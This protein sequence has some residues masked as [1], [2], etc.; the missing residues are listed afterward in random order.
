YI[1]SVLCVVYVLQAGHSVSAQKPKFCGK[2]DCPPFKV[3]NKTADYELRLYE[4]SEWV[5]NSRVTDSPFSYPVSMFW[6]LFWYIMGMNKGGKTMSWALP[7][8]M[9]ITLPTEIGQKWNIGMCF[10]LKSKS[11]PEP[12]NKK[13]FLIK[14]PA[15]KI[16]VRSFDGFAKPK[17]W[18]EHLKTLM[19]AL[20]DGSYE[21]SYFYT[22]AYNSPFQKKNRHN[23]VWL[24]AKN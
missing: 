19:N 10:Y 17:D 21:G 3:L 15:T 5:S 23:E 24:V 1:L 7:G 20:P 18:S 22:A 8:L 9:K 16:Y 11:N 2:Y 14:Q 13:V 6:N 12:N 4:A